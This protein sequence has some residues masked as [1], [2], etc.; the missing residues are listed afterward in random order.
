M[1]PS[2]APPL[3]H[4]CP[5]RPIHHSETLAFHYFPQLD[6]SPSVEIEVSESAVVDDHP[7]GSFSAIAIDANHCP[8]SI[9]F[10]TGK[11]VSTEKIEY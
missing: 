7:D 11:L 2:E 10:F 8:F 1:D 9:P 6:A 4:P 5:G 3:P